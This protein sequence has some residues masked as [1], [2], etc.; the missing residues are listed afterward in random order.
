MSCGGAPVGPAETEEAVRAACLRLLTSRPRSRSE[1]VQ[2]LRDKGFDHELTHRVVDRMVEVQLVD[3]AAFARTWV[4]SRHAYAG[5]GRR[6]LAVELR[7]KGIDDEHAAAALGQV[8]DEAEELRARELVWRKLR[9]LPRSG[10]QAERAAVVRKLVSMLARRGYPPD[11]AFVVV[12]DELA[13]AGVA[14]EGLDSV[15][16][17]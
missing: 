7:A 4:Q 1:L 14:T 16:Q 6:A 15:D 3:D 8:G 9:S 11:L 17:D 5:K 2:R 10:D 13:A 12:R